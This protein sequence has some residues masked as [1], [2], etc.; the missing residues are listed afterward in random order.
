MKT[1]RAA[2][3]GPAGQ[4][5]NHSGKESLRVNIALC[6]DRPVLRQMLETMI[7]GYEAENKVRFRICHF[8]SGEA[9]LE[10]FQE[11][12][13]CF[14]L[15]FLDQ[16]MKKLSGIATALRIRKYDPACNIVFCT[17]SELPSCQFAAVS[18]L[19]VLSK[20]VSME[21]IYAVLDKVWVENNAGRSDS[22]PQQKP[23]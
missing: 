16:C 14:E 12:K 2:R 21:D 10:Q 15:I 19:T 3:A 5:P 22:I 1:D 11:N 23:Q 7:H 4:G 9:L 6:D 20:P 17:A 18:P 8:D 13:T